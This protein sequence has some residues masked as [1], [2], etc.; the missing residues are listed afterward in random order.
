MPNKKKSDS[1]KIA[2]IVILIFILLGGGYFIAIFSTDSA[3]QIGSGKDYDKLSKN[4]D[5][6]SSKS[7]SPSGGNA[8]FDKNDISN[9]QNTEISAEEMNSR[10]L[11][12]G[13][14]EEARENISKGSS[15]SM[16]SS[17]ASER[18]NNSNADFS[19]G[20]KSGEVYGGRT[21]DGGDQSSG[22]SS[23]RYDEKGGS[24]L[25]RLKNAF[26][27]SQ[28]AV[29]D[30]TS[31][32]SSEKMAH[33]FSPDQLWGANALGMQAGGGG[34]SAVIED[35]NSQPKFLRNKDGFD[36]AKVEDSK[37]AAMDA[38]SEY[39]M[40]PGVVKLMAQENEP[41]KFDKTVEFM[42]PG[43]MNPMFMGLIPKYA[44]PEKTPYSIEFS[45][46]ANGRPGDMPSMASI[47]DENLIT[48]GSKMGF[49]VVYDMEGN[50]IGC[51]DNATQ[52][53]KTAGTPGCPR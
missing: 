2:A 29:N 32:G 18:I 51:M 31:E 7:D 6:Y 38:N 50:F 47:D 52:I 5:I 9:M 49:Q 46:L 22:I 24:V 16:A 41:S 45:N 36:N 20:K 12:S 48:Y 40:D 4:S 42:F 44:P 23:T 33:A 35:L 17:V 37:V 10:L 34:A 27:L 26:A 11:R 28:D 43:M 19:S 21:L 15:V 14:K 3:R 1:S 53:F 8:F 13:A 39:D 25:D 30:I